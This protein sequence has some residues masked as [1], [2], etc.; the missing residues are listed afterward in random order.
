M[1]LRAGENPA[2]RLRVYLLKSVIQ[3]TYANLHPQGGYID[4]IN[5]LSTNSTTGN[6]S[7]L[8]KMANSLHKGRLRKVSFGS[9]HLARSNLMSG[10]NFVR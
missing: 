3:A 8:A 2:Y 7:N 10:V 9:L 4:I 5:H 6:E 1:P